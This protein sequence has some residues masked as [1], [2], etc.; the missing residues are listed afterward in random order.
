MTDDFRYD[1]FFCHSTVDERAALPIAERLRADGL[2]I[3]APKWNVPPAGSFKA[4][5]EE[6]LENSRTLVFCMSANAF[7]SSWPRMEACTLRFR[8]PLNAQ[9]GFVALRLDQASIKPSL[10][11]YPHIDFTG[12]N[13]EEAY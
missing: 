10:S 11:Q 7:G 13:R 12:G 3:W 2:R 9:R 5:V 4:C 1:V 8:D 6:G